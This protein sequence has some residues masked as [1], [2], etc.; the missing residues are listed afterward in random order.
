MLT[1]IVVELLIALLL[2]GLGWRSYGYAALSPLAVVLVIL[3]ILWLLG[4]IHA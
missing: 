3:L 4:L 1:I 2:G